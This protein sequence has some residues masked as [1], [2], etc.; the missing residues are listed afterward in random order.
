ML[1]TLLLTKTAKLFNFKLS[2][3]NS[4]KFQG[5]EKHNLLTQYPKCSYSSNDLPREINMPV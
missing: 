5:I 3:A 4:S 2:R 1:V